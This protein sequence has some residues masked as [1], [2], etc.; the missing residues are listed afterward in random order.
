MSIQSIIDQARAERERE[1]IDQDEEYNHRVDCIFEAVIEALS[2][3]YPELILP[4]TYAVTEMY[5]GMPTGLLWEI[6][7]DKLRL[8]KL[9]VYGYY[10]DGEASSLIPEPRHI[11]EA[12]QRFETAYSDWW[13]S[14]TK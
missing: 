4:E 11:V 13:Q 1:Q 6:N 8:L 12:N 7:D 2:A 9:K 10:R 5:A 14:V 3:S